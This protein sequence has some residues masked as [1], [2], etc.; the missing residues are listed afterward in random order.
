M[1]S[2]RQRGVRG[3][4]AA[5]LAAL[6]PAPAA[7]G[8]LAS[9]GPWTLEASGFYKPALTGLVLQPSLVQGLASLQAA[10]DQAT[11]GGGRRLAVPAAAGLSTHTLRL[12]GKLLY[13]EALELEAAWQL[14][15][16]VASD[17][18]FLSTGASSFLGASLVTAQRRLWDFSPTLASA[19]GLALVHSLDR[20]ALTWRTGRFT[21]VV[22][23]QVLSWGTG[24]FWNPT[25]LVS[26]FAPTDLDREVRRGADAVRLSLGLGDTSQ[27]DLLW[28]PQVVAA[29]H[30]GVVRAR[31]NF[32]GWDVSATVGKYARDLVLGADFA[33][34]LWV[35]GVHGEAAWTL[36][37]VGL[38]GAAPLGVSG[39]FLRAVVGVDWRPLEKLLLGAE[40]QFNGFG[41]KS[42]W[43]LLV[44]LRDPR[45]T[46]GEQFGAARHAL[47]LTATVLASELVTVSFTA[48]ANLGDPS[49][50]L[51]PS[52]EYALAQNVLLRVGASLP[53]GQGVDTGFLDAVTAAD[54]L[55]QT[56]AWERATTTLGARSEYGLSSYGLFVQVGLYFN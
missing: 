18:A 28:L 31:A 5:V 45:V 4:A 8:V 7:A 49:A 2:H 42:P 36:P 54:A 19:G 41:A 25:D 55:G 9:D 17:P 11:P 34:D 29:D 23:R 32:G 46:R 51:L 38:D 13:G 6:L 43:G 10:L 39:D 47:A 40:Y 37:L 24:R 50:L 56:A 48:L 30:G 44:K 52:L 35:L 21:L 22:G 53:L 14:T 26:P 12:G 3:A 33:G 15:G 27:L 20:L 16:L 1:G